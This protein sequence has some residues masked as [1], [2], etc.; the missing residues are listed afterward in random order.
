METMQKK[1]QLFFISILCLLTLVGQNLAFASMLCCVEPEQPVNNHSCCPPKVKP[2]CHEHKEVTSQK[3]AYQKPHCKMQQVSSELILYKANGIVFE[4]MDMAVE[5]SAH[6][7]H[8]LQ[9]AKAR[10]PVWLYRL[11]YPD[12]SELYIEQQRLLL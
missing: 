7:S 5:I 6:P 2:P 10:T 12:K 1:L 3:S 4:N 8:S 11:F 9:E